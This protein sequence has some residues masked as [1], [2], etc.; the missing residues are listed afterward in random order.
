[1]PLGTIASPFPA[2]HL[3]PN[4]PWL[5]L[6]PR[7]PHDAVRSPP[8]LPTRPPTPHLRENAPLLS[9]T[10]GSVGSRQEQCLSTAKPPTPG[11][12]CGRLPRAAARAKRTRQERPLQTT[13]P[14]TLPGP[15]THLQPTA[16]AGTSRGG[17]QESRREP[18]LLQRI[19]LARLPLPPTNVKPQKQDSR[20]LGPLQAALPGRQALRRAT[21]NTYVP[22]PLPPPPLIVLPLPKG[23]GNPPARTQPITQL[24]RELD[25]TFWRPSAEHAQNAAAL[26][27]SGAQKAGEPEP[28]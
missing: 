11:S 7:S 20:E 27:Y 18:H 10:H 5:H 14:T 23:L 19:L 24:L 1:M 6:C 25:P 28:A 15:L 22:P 2:R 26:T 12:R 13:T 17:Q 3:I 9:R 8:S 16:A 4:K 21:R